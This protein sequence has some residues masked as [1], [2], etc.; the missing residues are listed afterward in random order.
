VAFWDFGGAVSVTD[1]TFT[2]AI[3]ADGLMTATV[4]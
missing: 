3:N 2:L 1:G 4:S